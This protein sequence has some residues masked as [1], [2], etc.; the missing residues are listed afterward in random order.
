MDNQFHPT[1]YDGYVITYEI[2]GH[3]LTRAPRHDINQVLFP[4]LV[5]TVFN[6]ADSKFDAIY[7][8]TKD[9][10]FLFRIS[11]LQTSKLKQNTVNEINYTERCWLI[12]ISFGHNDLSGVRLWTDFFWQILDVPKIRFHTSLGCRHGGLT[13]QGILIRFT[14]LWPRIKSEYLK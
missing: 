10:V 9:V 2:K 14:Q 11:K 5:R 7:Y 12:V 8:Q 6:K 4:R 3:W 1:F 13:W